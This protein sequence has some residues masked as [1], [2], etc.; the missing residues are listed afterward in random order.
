MVE[1]ALGN[2][3]TLSSFLYLFKP[4]EESKTNFK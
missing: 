2:N 1:I 4:N 3:F